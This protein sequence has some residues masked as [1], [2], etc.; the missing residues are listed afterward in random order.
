MIENS[1]VLIVLPLAGTLPLPVHPLQTYCVVP[2]VTGEFITI[3]LVT[4]L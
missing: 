1:P 3:A 4:V 2:L